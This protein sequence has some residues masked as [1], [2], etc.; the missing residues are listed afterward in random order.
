MDQVCF[1]IRKD[2]E[3]LTVKV[4]VLSGSVFLTGL[5]RFR[6]YLVYLYSPH[7]ENVCSMHPFHKENL[8]KILVPYF[9]LQDK[10]FSLDLRGF[11]ISYRIIK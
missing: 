3:I 9:T 11:T 4:K 6:L 5:T 7:R 1:K 8:I 10:I 2:A